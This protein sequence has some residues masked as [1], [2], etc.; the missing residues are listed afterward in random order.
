MIGY[1]V[2]VSLPITIERL[3]IYFHAREISVLLLI[4]G[5]SVLIFLER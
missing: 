3:E 5:C 1:F 2:N 4:Q